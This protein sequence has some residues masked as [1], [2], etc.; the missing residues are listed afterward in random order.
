MCIDNISLAEVMSLN[1]NTFRQKL[2]H[3]LIVV[4]QVCVE[5]KNLM[6]FHPD[7]GSICVSLRKEVDNKM[8]DLT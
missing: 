8:R 7:L 1:Y 3:L 6:G 2:Y 5:H 4:D